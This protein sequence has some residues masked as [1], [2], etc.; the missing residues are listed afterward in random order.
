VTRSVADRRRT[1][2]WIG[3]AVVLAVALV[4]GV[5]SDPPPRSDADR[6]RAL[7]E[8]IACPQCDGQSVADSDSPAAQGVRSVIDE[9]IAEGASDAEI[10]D[11]LAAAY[12]PRVLLTP[13]RTGVSSLVWT[14]PVIAL[15]VAVAGLAFTFRRWRRA[16]AARATDA[17]RELVAQARGSG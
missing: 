15:V 8:T 10:R 9:R 3:L 6:A 11:E 2:G 4:V 17:D 7:A 1:L 14:L 5:A 13:G 16:G 12:G